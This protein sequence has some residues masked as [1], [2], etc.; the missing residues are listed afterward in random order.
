M[1]NAQHQLTVIFVQLWRIASAMTKEREHVH[2]GATPYHQTSRRVHT[3]IH[4]GGLTSARDMQRSLRNE[5]PGALTLKRVHHSA[6]AWGN[7]V[8]PGVNTHNA[9]GQPVM[10]A[11]GCEK[12]SQGTRLT[13]RW[14]CKSI[15]AVRKTVSIRDVSNL[16]TLP[17]SRCSI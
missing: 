11:R 13:S 6:V 12:Q 2:Q 5:L 15:A 3:S 7:K 4:M 14:N 8:Q 17:R 1:A 9:R 10:S 16:R